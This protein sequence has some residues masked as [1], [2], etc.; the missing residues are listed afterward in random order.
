MMCG[1][2]PDHALPPTLLML[3]HS[4]CMVLHQL[5]SI[6]QANGGRIGDM[7]TCLRQA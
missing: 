6:E 1:L 4:R 2:W 5:L 3:V 7:H